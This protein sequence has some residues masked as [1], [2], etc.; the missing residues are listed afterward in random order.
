MVSRKIPEKW[1]S[2][3]KAAKATQVAFDLDER[4]QMHIRREALE[5]G[6]SPSDRIREILGLPVNKRPKRPRLTV[7]LSGEDYQALAEKYGLDASQQLEI[8]RKL[9]EDLVIHVDKEQQ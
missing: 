9:M 7:S 1:Q 8:K 3:V 5:S 2:S 4:F 6:L